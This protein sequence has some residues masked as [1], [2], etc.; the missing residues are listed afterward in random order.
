MV[1]GRTLRSIQQR[2][3][4]LTGDPADE[5]AHGRRGA[6]FRG[7]PA[8][9]FLPPLPGGGMEPCTQPGGRSDLL[10]P[11]VIAERLL[12]DR[13]EEPRFFLYLIN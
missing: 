5:V 4:T 8:A 10:R 12:A 9:E 2:N 13:S 11:Q 1:S 6:Q 3:R 7:I